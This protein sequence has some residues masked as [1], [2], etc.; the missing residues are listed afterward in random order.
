MYNRNS[1]TDSCSTTSHDYSCSK[2][3]CSVSLTGSEEGNSDVSS[4]VSSEEI[5]ILSEDTDEETDKIA[6]QTLEPY[7]YKPVKTSD[8]EPSTVK[9]NHHQMKN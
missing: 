9:M 8:T 2:S 4:T 1:S 3:P 7:Q 6:G 5:D